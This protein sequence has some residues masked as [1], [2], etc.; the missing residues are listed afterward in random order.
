MHS[1]THRLARGTAAAA[2]ATLVAALSHTAGGGAFPSAPLLALAFVV[3]V[4]WCTAVVGRRFSWTRVSAAVVAS[5]ALFHGTFALV[6]AGGARVVAET[7]GHSAHAGS[8]T[9]TVLANGSG[10]AHDGV[11]M[12]AAHGVAA[13]VTIVALRIAD[14]SSL[15]T[16]ALSHVVRS[17][18]PAL[19]AVPVAIGSHLARVRPNGTGFR[20]S[21]IAVILTGLRRRGPPVLITAA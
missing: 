17:L 11:G 12:L 5:Q 4:G 6:G 10:H 18:F 19:T 16:A 1:R 3:S 20:P 15:A 14:R 2:I 13:A 7:A 9:L 21:P 8:T